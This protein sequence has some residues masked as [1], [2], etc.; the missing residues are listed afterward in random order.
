[1]NCGMLR[2]SFS[3]VFAFSRRTRSPTTDKSIINKRLAIAEQYLL[4]AEHDICDAIIDYFDRSTR[5]LDFQYGSAAISSH[6]PEYSLL[7]QRTRQ[8]QDLIA[9][10][11]HDFDKRAANYKALR[12]RHF[13]ELVEYDRH[14]YD[15]EITAHIQQDQ[16]ENQLT[17]ARAKVGIFGWIGAV[18]AISSIVAV[19]L[20]VY[21]WTLAYDDFCKLHGSRRVIATIC[22]PVPPTYP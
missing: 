17:I 15:A 8:C 18:G 20:A 5:D 9:E 22:T 13:P 21:L 3:M 11:R 2:G 4:N 6:F 16:L 10:A 7:K 19:P 14:L 1:M 12:E